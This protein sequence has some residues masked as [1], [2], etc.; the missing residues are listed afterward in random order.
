MIKKK[1]S[2][3]S[4]HCLYGVAEKIENAVVTLTLVDQMTLM[5]R[6]RRAPQRNMLAGFL[7]L[8]YH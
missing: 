2:T 6:N 4:A 7:M 5:Q 3:F 1:N 8:M